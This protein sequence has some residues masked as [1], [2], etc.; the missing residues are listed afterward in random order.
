MLIRIKIEFVRKKKS[1]VIL[2]HGAE[3]IYLLGLFK[4]RK[5]AL[6]A[7]NT[8][9]CKPGYWRQPVIAKIIDC[10]DQEYET[11]VNQFIYRAVTGERT[12]YSAK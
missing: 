3:T 12:T 8:F 6:K 1:A 5:R 2:R 9:R 4:N 11:I 10:T 7:W